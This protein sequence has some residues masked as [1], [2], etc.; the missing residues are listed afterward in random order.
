MKQTDATGISCLQMADEI[1]ED[2]RSN[3]ELRYKDVVAF[4]IHP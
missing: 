2:K 1:E 3:V 4:R